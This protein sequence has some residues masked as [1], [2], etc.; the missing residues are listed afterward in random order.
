[1]KKLLTTVLLLCNLSWGFATPTDGLSNGFLNI[2]DSI[3]TGH[4]W[5]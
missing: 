2:P 4:F 3:K 5:Y 1:M